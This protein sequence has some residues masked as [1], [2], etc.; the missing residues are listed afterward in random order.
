M[1]NIDLILRI[2]GYILCPLLGI[3]YY[4]LTNRV[5]KL[6]LYVEAQPEAIRNRMLEYVKPIEVRVEKLESRDESI[7]EMKTAIALI[8]QKL[9]NIEKRLDSIDDKDKNKDK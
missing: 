9:I 3:I 7:Y 1:D 6:E 8:L 2:I 5:K 4:G